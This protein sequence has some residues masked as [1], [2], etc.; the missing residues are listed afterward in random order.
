MFV[1]QSRS[2]SKKNI[3]DEINRIKQVNQSIEQTKAMLNNPNFAN[4]PQVLDAAK[5]TLRQLEARKKGGFSQG[6][7]RSAIDPSKIMQTG[8]QRQKLPAQS[9]QVPMEQRI[10]QIN[11]K[12]QMA[13]KPSFNVGDF[14]KPKPAQPT[15]P[16]QSPN[17]NQKTPSGPKPRWFE[18]LFINT[19]GNPRNPKINPSRLQTSG[20][21]TPTKQKTPQDFQQ[22]LSGNKTTATATPPKPTPKEAPQ[23]EPNQQLAPTKEET[24]EEKSKLSKVKSRLESLLQSAKAIGEQDRVNAVQERL[25]LVEDRLASFN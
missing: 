15:Q 14:L 6:G 22:K 19:Q 8:Q 11:Q 12:N 16:A 3:Q 25:N 17:L 13:Q 10:E 20:Q 5:K 24:Q 7:G 18:R 1:S 4:N 23:T 21:K 2:S 9:G